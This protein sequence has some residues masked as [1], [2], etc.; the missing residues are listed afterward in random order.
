MP[1]ASGKLV[2]AQKH[3]EVEEGL[4]QE[5][6]TWKQLM[7]ANNVLGLQPLQKAA[8]MKNVQVKHKVYK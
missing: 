7:V 5:N 2:H 6:E 1:G 3:V 8:M 4:I